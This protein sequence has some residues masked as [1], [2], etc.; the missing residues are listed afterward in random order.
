MASLPERIVPGV[1]PGRTIQAWG[2]LKPTV[3]RF[4]FDDFENLPSEIGKSTRSTRVTDGNGNSWELEL[5]PGGKSVGGGNMS[6]FLYNVGGNDVR[7]K[8]TYITRNAAGGVHNQQ[9]PTSLD[10]Y[11]STEGYGQNSWLKRSDV[12]GKGKNILLNGALLIDVELLAKPLRAYVPS[13]PHTKNMLALLDSGDNA[14]VTFKVGG[15][16]IPAHKLIIQTNA[17]LL[18]SFC[19][20]RGKAAVQINN[21][22]AEVFRLVLR[23]IYGG[24]APG[25]D[26]TKKWG[27]KLIDAA[28]RYGIVGL[29]MAVE[30]TLVECLEIRGFNVVDWLLFADAKTCPLIKEYATSLFTVRAKDLLASNESSKLKESPALMQELFMATSE[31]C[32]SDERFG[33]TATKMTVNE[34]RV[35]LDKKGLDVDGSKEML[36]SRLGASKKRQRDE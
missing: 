29:K 16:T 4:K 28:N 19:P 2:S 5:Y 31:T 17:P 25:E 36:I 18:Y 24:S 7:A 26:E 32:D 12:L 23:Y 30:T 15:T 14:D 20:K 10:C 6:M 8:V 22:N 3:L 35:E 33:G 34:L 1:T 13:N 9:A 21:T 11:G 27:K